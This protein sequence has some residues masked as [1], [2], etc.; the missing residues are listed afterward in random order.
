MYKVIAYSFFVSPQEYFVETEEE[1]KEL[2]AELK[3]QQYSVDIEE[4]EEYDE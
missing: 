4:I 3:N 1:A 2:K